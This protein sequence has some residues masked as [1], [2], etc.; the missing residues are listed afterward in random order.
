MMEATAPEFVP[1]MKLNDYVDEGEL[2][3]YLKQDIQGSYVLKGKFTK[4]LES[5][6]DFNRPCEFSSSKES[7]SD[8]KQIWESN[9]MKISQNDLENTCQFSSTKENQ[10]E[11]KQIWNTLPTFEN[12]GGLEKTWDS[13]SSEK[14]QV[15]LERMW[16]TFPTNNDNQDGLE[17]TTESSS[18]KESQAEEHKSINWFGLDRFHSRMESSVF[19]DKN[20]CLLTEDPFV[21]IYKP[22][23]SRQPWVNPVSSNMETSLPPCYPWNDYMEPPH[24]YWCPEGQKCVLLLST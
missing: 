16:E 2:C 3:A 12:V 9:S 17:K 5:K 19:R 23:Q 15:G 7:S 22:P 4:L 8:L 18:I 21:F 13:S 6:A 11:L 10:G 20:L 1:R 24:D 14:S